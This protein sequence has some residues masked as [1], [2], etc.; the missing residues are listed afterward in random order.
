MN[1]RFGVPADLK[2]W[3]LKQ[4]PLLFKQVATKQENFIQIRKFQVDRDAE[5]PIT[6]FHLGALSSP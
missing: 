5:P 1:G 2:V 4:D 3:N 6:I